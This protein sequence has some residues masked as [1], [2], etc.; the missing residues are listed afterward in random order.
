MERVIIKSDKPSRTV[1]SSEVAKLI[2]ENGVILVYEQDYAVGHV[3]RNWTAGTWEITTRDEEASYTDFNDL[4]DDY[5][6]YVF[7]YVD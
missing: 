4:L 6:F 2:E 1:T 3:V 5:A 7:K